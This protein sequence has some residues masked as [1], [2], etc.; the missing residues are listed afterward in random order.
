MFELRV[1]IRCFLVLVGGLSF[2][3]QGW[4]QV[5]FAA[6]RAWGLETHQ[7]TDRTLRIP[8]SQLFAETALLSG[9][10]SGG[11]NGRAFV[12]PASTQFRVFNTL[13][14]IQPITYVPTLRTFAD[15]LHTAYWDDG[16][17]SGA[18]GGDRFYDDNAHLVVAL[19]EAYRL[20][21]DN[22]YLNRAKDTQ[23]FVLQGED[24]V[25]G[26]GV[27]FK[28]FDF[29]SKD[30]ISTLQGT[31]GAAM[32]YRATGDPSYLNDATRLLTWAR[33]HIQRLRWYV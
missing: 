25:A 18:G 4:A 14:Q 33:T 16:Y 3:V 28:Q 31:R 1:C 7:E 21:D 11:F 20:T 8:G 6:L 15:D 26:G 24:S 10:Q 5:N 13:A 19:V 22:V 27:Y 23:A 12:W 29:S 2:T 32:L 9:A 30:A 17:R